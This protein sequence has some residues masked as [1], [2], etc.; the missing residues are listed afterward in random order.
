MNYLYSTAEQ[1]NWSK[2]TK[3]KVRSSI[4]NVLSRK[5]YLN[6]EW[7]RIKTGT[8]QPIVKD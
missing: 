2:E 3:D 5:T 8:Y 7:K 1:E 6:K 4:S